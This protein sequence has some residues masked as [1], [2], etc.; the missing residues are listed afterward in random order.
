M[1]RA[2]VEQIARNHRALA[3]SRALHDIADGAAADA[4]DGRRL[5]QLWKELERNATEYCDLYNQAFGAVRIRSEFHGDTIVVRSES[6]QEHTLVLRR[7]LPAHG[8]PASV[9]AH[10]YHY[11]EPPLDL[12]VSLAR[13]GGTLQLIHHGEEAN[14]AELVVELVSAFAEELALADSRRSEQGG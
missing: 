2:R 7:T 8:H 1:D 10:R 11:T 14:P 3:Q 13:G 4:A 9:E 5:E 12:P 6:D